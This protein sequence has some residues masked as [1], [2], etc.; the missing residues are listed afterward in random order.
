MVSYLTGDFGFREFGGLFLGVFL[1]F[2]RLLDD[3]F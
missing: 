2:G 1:W 3:L